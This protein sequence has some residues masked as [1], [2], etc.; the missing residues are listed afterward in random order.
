MDKYLSLIHISLIHFL[1]IHV[2]NKFT[3]WE[4]INLDTGQCSFVIPSKISQTHSVTNNNEA[5]PFFSDST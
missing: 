2:S 4:F 5:F 3:E 1:V